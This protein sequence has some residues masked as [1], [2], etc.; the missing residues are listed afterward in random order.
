MSVR[1]LN[2]ERS[3]GTLMAQLSCQ[4]YLLVLLMLIALSLPGNLAVPDAQI[5]EPSAWPEGGR[6]YNK[7]VSQTEFSTANRFC[8]Q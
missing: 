6:A 7:M 8:S 3:N 2:L 1:T 4:S 5:V